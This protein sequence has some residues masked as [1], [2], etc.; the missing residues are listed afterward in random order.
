[1]IDRGIWTSPKGWYLGV[2][3]IGKKATDK[4]VRNKMLRY[5]VDLAEYPA[6][7]LLSNAAMAAENKPAYNFYVK[8]QKKGGDV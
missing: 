4:Y 8:Y 1:M 5:P 7:T 2:H 3:S 6:Q